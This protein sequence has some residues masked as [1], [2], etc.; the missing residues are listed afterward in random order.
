MQADLQPS[1]TAN[2]PYIHWS[3]Y[4]LQLV[5]PN[6]GKNKSVYH[7]CQGQESAG[8]NMQ[9]FPLTPPLN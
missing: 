3:N 2:L 7:N 9:V 6:Q 4:S 1:K 8:I 5:Y